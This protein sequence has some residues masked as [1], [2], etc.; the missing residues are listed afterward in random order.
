MNNEVNPEIEKT[1]PTEFIIVITTTNNAEEAE[2]LAG[3]LVGQKA[4]ACVS[5]SSAIT[6]LYRWKNNV[7]KEQE[8]MLLIKTVKGNYQAVERLIR[9]NHS[10]EVPEIIA[11]PVISGEEKYLHWLAENTKIEK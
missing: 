1:H 7:E 8:F 9:Q 5:I 6:S 3:L 10:Y 4:A 11:L 2:K